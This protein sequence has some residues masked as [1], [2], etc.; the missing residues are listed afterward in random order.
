MEGKSHVS[1]PSYAHVSVPYLRMLSF[2]LLAVRSPLLLTPP[3]PLPR[4]WG[5]H[6]KEVKMLVVS[7]R[8]VNFV[9]CSHLACS[10]QN[11]I[12]ISRLL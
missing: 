11:A 12:I 6:M 1:Y 8:V 4:G 7:L 10:E 9:F 5:S 2:Y 3:Y